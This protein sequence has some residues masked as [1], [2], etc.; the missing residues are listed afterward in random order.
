MGAEKERFSAFHQT[1]KIPLRP[2]VS[3]NSSSLR[4]LKQQTA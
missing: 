1:L 2:S 4:A 3:V